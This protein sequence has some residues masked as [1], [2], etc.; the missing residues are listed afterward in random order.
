MNMEFLIPISMAAGLVLIVNQIGRILRA[1]AMQRTVRHAITANSDAVPILLDRIEEKP[2]SGGNDDRTGLVLIAL[3]VALIGCG[4]LTQSDPD[5][6]RSFIGIALFPAL[7]GAVLFGRAW[8]MRR[9][10]AVS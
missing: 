1:Y 4:L 6:I 10:G 8:Y 3:A 2:E 5:D 9:R 7:V